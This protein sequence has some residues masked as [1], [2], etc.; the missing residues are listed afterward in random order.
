MGLQ[1]PGEL[2]DLLNELGYTWPKSDETK[3]FELAQRWLQFAGT[4]GSMPGEARTAGQAV[5]ADNHGTA[6]TAFAQRWSADKSAVSVLD[7]CVTGS[8][9]MGA[10]LVV[11]AAVVLALKINVIVQL[12]IL[13]IEIIEAIASAPPTFG[14][15]LLEIPVFKKLTD[16][17]I[18]YLIGQAMEAI[19]G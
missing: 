17:A 18:N 10:C 1:L 8:Q 6:M 19:L 4:V 11:C 9:V 12:T 7:D 14:A 2:A 13:L 3:L 16:I 15:S 5:L